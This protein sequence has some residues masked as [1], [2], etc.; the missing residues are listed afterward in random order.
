M[1]NKIHYLKTICLTGLLLAALGGTAQKKGTGG[2]A[3]VIAAGPPP[4]CPPH[5]A[6]KMSELKFMPN[7]SSYCIGDNFSILY[8]NPM[9]HTMVN[10][11][12]IFQGPPPQQ[13]LNTV[14]TTF[15]INNIQGPGK[16]VF[17]G[18]INTMAVGACTFNLNFPINVTTNL[19]A[20]AGPDI[21]VST[22]FPSG[23][24][25]GYPA[26]TGGQPGYTYAWT[27]NTNI[28]NTTISNPQV[29]PATTTV[30][31]LVAT[32]ANNCVSPP[33]QVTVYN[34]NNLSNPNQTYY[35]VLKKKLDGGYYNTILFNGAQT[36][37]FKFDEEYYKPGVNNNLNYSI[38][39]D[40]N[41]PVTVPSLIKNIGDNRF[42]LSA[43]STSPALTSGAYYTLVVKNEKEETWQARF[44][45]N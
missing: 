10:L 9:N 8:F 35:A 15:S 21:F 27:P 18:T 25:G 1:K 38:V 20:N 28:N 32:D 39:D 44:K 11:N 24:I 42:T 22:T 3:V 17:T 30:Y 36:L 29:N 16:V 31:Q 12:W 37:F 5:L 40:G 23:T 43:N 26:A 4:P 14:S 6:P 33:D 34:I 2:G 7:K 19:F 41:N 13:L 45:V